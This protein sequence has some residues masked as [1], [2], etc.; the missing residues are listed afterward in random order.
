MP[1]SIQPPFQN[2]P[3]DDPAAYIVWET[4]TIKW[5]TPEGIETWDVPV[6]QLVLENLNTHRMV[7]MAP[8]YW[9]TGAA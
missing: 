9:A 3:T 1:A 7:S 2:L 5:K 6:V 4:R 8:R